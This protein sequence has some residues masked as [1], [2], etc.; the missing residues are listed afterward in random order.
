MMNKQ[1]VG[2]NLQDMQDL[3]RGK[4]TTGSASTLTRLPTQSCS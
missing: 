3:Q 1:W 2:A 4:A